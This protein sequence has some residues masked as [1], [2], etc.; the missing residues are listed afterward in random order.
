[1]LT[2]ESCL[3]YIQLAIEEADISERLHRAY[4]NRTV[5]K[6]H[7]I[8]SRAVLAVALATRRTED[9]SSLMKDGEVRY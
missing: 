3:G 4:G 5:K 7:E 6:K 2:Q 1:M 8:M 9:Q